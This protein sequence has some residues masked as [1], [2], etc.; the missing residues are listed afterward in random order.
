MEKELNMMMDICYL[1]ENLIMVKDGM[2][3]GKNLMD[4]II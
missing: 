1:K 2:E 4:L 3:E